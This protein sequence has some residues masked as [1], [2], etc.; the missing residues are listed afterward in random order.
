[1]RNSNPDAF[2]ESSLKS[3]VLNRVSHTAVI[4]RS[5]KNGCVT[6]VMHMAVPSGPIGRPGACVGDNGVA[7]TATPLLRS[8]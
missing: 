8:L 5:L 4:E 6:L 1:M 2:F 7:A 3:G